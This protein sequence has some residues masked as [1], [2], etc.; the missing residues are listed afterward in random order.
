MKKF[1]YLSLLLVIFAGCEEDAVKYASN[2]ESGVLGLMG[3]D[4]ENR[5]DFKTE[6]DW[7]TTSE[8]GN[9]DGHFSFADANGNANPKLTMHGTSTPATLRSMPKSNRK[10]IWRANLVFEVPNIDSSYQNVARKVKELGGYIS[11]LNQQGNEYRMNHTLQIRVGAENF[12][13]LVEELKSEAIVIEKLQVNSQDVSEEYVDLNARLKTK[14]EARTRYM[15]ILKKKTGSVKDVIE[16]E[17][18]IRRIT[19]EIES[20]E[21]RLRY[22]NDRIKLSSISL[23]LY[24]K[25]TTEDIPEVEEITFGD[26]LLSSLELGWKFILGVLLFFITIWPAVLI[27]LALL[28]WKRKWFRKTK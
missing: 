8:F 3:N 21:G 27:L 26:R 23:V 15:D 5:T 4:T 1:L 9:K 22:L 24:Q 28:I 20:K 25:L 10:I 12:D 7:A 17:D 13:K 11:N 16:A 2:E 14:K 19:E 18:A 6:P